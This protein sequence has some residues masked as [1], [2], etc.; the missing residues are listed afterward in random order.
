MHLTNTF[1]HHLMRTLNK[2]WMAPHPQCFNFPHGSLLLWK[3]GSQ[4][5]LKGC[6]MSVFATVLHLYSLHRQWLITAKDKTNDVC[7]IFLN[8]WEL[9]FEFGTQGQKPEKGIKL[10]THSFREVTQTRLLVYKPKTSWS[11]KNQTAEKALC[12]WF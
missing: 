1:T 12:Y 3:S 2:D 6:F 5:S 8:K 4:C 9:T 10:S 11:L 7:D